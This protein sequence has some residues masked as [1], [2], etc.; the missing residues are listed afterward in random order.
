MK[1]I[2]HTP[3]PVSR[4]NLNAA[5]PSMFKALQNIR[6]GF[7]IG[8]ITT[9]YADEQTAWAYQQVCAALAIAK[10]DASNAP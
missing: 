7:E 3:R 6:N 2:T 1:T 4:D 9:D 8:A 10:G 5:A